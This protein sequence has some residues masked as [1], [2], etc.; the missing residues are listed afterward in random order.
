MAQVPDYQLRDWIARLDHVAA[1]PDL[2]SETADELG[3]LAASL[4][5]ALGESHPITTDKRRGL[6]RGLESLIPTGA[7]TGVD[8]ESLRDRLR[9]IA[10]S[11][12]ASNPTE[13]E[14]VSHGPSGG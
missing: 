12:T 14:G 8:I 4:R 2:D 11:A 7:E 3:L 6:G 13:P 1:A 10:A 9:R 5:H